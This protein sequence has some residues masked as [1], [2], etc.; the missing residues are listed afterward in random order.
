MA[1]ISA[2]TLKTGGD[3]LSVSVDG[4]YDVVA[5]LGFVPPALVGVLAARF[6]DLMDH[7]R[8]KVANNARDTWPGGGR[9][10]QKFIFAYSSVYGSKNRG[11]P[12]GFG[13][14]VGES[15]LVSPAS[16]AGRFWENFE[17]GGRVSAG[18]VMTV[19]F[20]KGSGPIGRQNLFASRVQKTFAKLGISSEK[21][22]AVIG[23]TKG[24]FDITRGGLLTQTGE[25]NAR[26]GEGLRTIFVGKLSRSVNRRPILKFN[27]SFEAIFPK[28]AAKF[29]DAMER[30]LTIAGNESLKSELVRSQQQ[31][32]QGNRSPGR[33]RSTDFERGLRRYL[34]GRDFSTLRDELSAA[35]R[36]RAAK[37]ESTIRLAPAQRIG[38]GAA[39]GQAA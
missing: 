10:A 17:R 29:D 35:V 15:F 9:A 26:T 30:A 28:H 22:N 32:G 21:A 14:L 6:Y 34:A 1:K 24:R 2:T 33:V 5:T 4:I 13:D 8:K 37:G 38:R 39:G 11:K 12:Q 31:V 19:P 20:E 3:E 7:H 23:R 36:D 18:G 25:A 16:V 27:A